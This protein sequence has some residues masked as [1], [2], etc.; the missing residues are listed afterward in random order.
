MRRSAAAHVRHTARSLGLVAL[1]CV[2]I[3]LWLGV[4][5]VLF[6]APEFPR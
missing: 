4:A 2:C 6:A 1:W 5:L 3:S